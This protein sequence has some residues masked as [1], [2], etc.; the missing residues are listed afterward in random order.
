MTWVRLSDDWNRA[1]TLAGVP[2]LARLLHVDALTYSNQQLLD[3]ALPLAVARALGGIRG[4]SLVD[5]L[6]EA[7]A[8]ART[9]STTI[10][11]VTGLEHQ[12]TRAQV[13]QMRSDAT[14]RKARSRAGHT[15]TGGERHGV[16]PRPSRRE[17]AVTPAELRPLPI[18]IP[19]EAPPSHGGGASEAPT[20]PHPKPRA[21]TPTPAA[22]GRVPGVPTGA[23]L[24]DMLALGAR[25]RPGAAIP[26]T[27]PDEP[28]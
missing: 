12:P 8:W 26:E 2:A 22:V 11:I 3:G 24:A 19:S 13:Q 17:T 28:E 27:V 15:V 23:T 10:Q 6:I 20:H 25:L 5:A 21:G 16:T 7:G 9:S 4:V 1:P 14:A 18:P